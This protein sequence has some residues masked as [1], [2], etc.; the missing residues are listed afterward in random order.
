VLLGGLGIAGV[1]L[2]ATVTATPAWAMVKTCTDG[3]TLKTSGSCIIPAGDTS[4]TVEAAG[5]L[6]G[7]GGAGSGTIVG[8]T[9]G[10]GAI[11]LG[12]FSVTPGQTLQFTAGT[13]GSPGTEDPGNP[14]AGG[15][16]GGGNGGLAG[17]P[18]ANLGGGGGGGGLSGVVNES[19]GASL[20]IAGGGGGGGGGGNTAE[21]NAN[22]N[23]GN[24]GGNGQNGANAEGTGGVAGASTTQA[25]GVG[26]GPT[27]NEAGGG[28]GGGGCNGGGGGS[29][30]STARDN[31]SGGGGGA[32]GSC[33]GTADVGANAGKGFVRL[34]FAPAALTFS[35]G[36]GKVGSEV[37]IGGKNLKGATAVTFNGISASIGADS[38]TSIKATVPSGAT[39]GPIAVTTVGGTGTTSKSFKVKT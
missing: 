25:G 5:A 32:G 39:T 24:G 23:G 20:L 26:G 28:G 9:G 31:G 13:I 14:G 16:P 12:S 7:D 21:G 2:A 15:G 27:T 35:P 10:D 33:G 1:G 18:N 34:Y 38:S 11:W 19:S 37:T 8:G 3:K 29:S 22:D 6:G 4:V 30:G 17:G 36:K